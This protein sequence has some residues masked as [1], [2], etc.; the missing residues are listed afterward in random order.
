MRVL[1]TRPRPDGERTAAILR[2]RGHDVLLTPSMQVRPVPAVLAGNWSAVIVS[3][4]NALRV[5]PA[6]Q[7]APLLRLPLY[8]IGERSAETA[9]AAGFREVRWSHGD[10]NALVHLVAERYA[11][12]I[13]PHL[14]LAGEH[15]AADIE[16]ALGQKGI[17][18]ATVVVYRNMTTGFPPE[19]IDAMER[20]M[21]DAALHFSRRSAENFVAGAE[22]AGLVAQALTPRHL[23]LSEQVAEPLRV[24]GARNVAAARRPDETALLELLQ[25]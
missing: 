25:T 20:G 6:D 8:A 1:V 21:I 5:L 16:G 15:R 23:C 24:A 22:S 9:R 13:A 18:V 17:R 19:L 7:L 4:S 14:Y 10:A 3:S 2:T 11:N 12:E